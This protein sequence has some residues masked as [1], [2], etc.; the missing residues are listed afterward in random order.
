M[1]G[2]PFDDLSKLRLDPVGIKVPRVPEKIQKRQENFIKVPWW[3]EKLANPMPASRYTVLIALHLLHLH[4]RS[5]GE[6]FKLPN[7][8]LR[9]DGIDRFSKR[10]SLKDLEQRGL[11]TVE[12]RERKSPII[13][14]HLV[15]QCNS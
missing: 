11:I 7:G 15:L 8:T 2:D 4:W 5:R 13:H 14:V 10:R 3:Y 1:T 6:P 9:Y 12:W